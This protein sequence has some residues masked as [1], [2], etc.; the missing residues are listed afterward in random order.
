MQSKTVLIRKV[1]KCYLTKKKGIAQ[2][3]IGA[4]LT[5]QEQVRE[6]APGKPMQ[7]KGISV[8]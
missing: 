1:R 3:K 5:H 6:P 7:R 2:D 4:R 8:S